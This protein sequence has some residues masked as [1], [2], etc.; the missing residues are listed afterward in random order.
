MNIIYISGPI[1]GMRN[2]NRRNFEKAAKK[3]ADTFTDCRVISPMQIGLAV[4]SD[5]KRPE[6]PEWADYMRGCVKSLMDA[7]H[8]YFIKGWQKSRGALLER[9]IAEGLEIPCAESIE[10]LK[11]IISGGEK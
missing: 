11:K 2:N 9:N 10:E 7:T 5:Q 3:L 8:V 1:S 6:K 4:E